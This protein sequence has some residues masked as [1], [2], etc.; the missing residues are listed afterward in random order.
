VKGIFLIN[1]K[2]LFRINRLSLL[3]SFFLAKNCLAQD[4]SFRCCTLKKQGSW[5]FLFLA[6][7]R[8]DRRMGLDYFLTSSQGFIRPRNKHKQW[9]LAK[10]IHFFPS[11]HSLWVMIV[12]KGYSV[13]SSAIF[14]VIFVVTS[15]NNTGTRHSVCFTVNYQ[16]ASLQIFF[17]FV[18]MFFVS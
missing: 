10:S 14:W 6:H 13:Q 16:S 7:G 17:C 5:A 3:P 2:N 11:S 9:E 4:F 1:P 12:K 8:Q 18:R 15:K